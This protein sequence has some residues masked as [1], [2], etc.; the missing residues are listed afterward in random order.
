MGKKRVG[1][2]KEG[3]RGGHSGTLDC[4]R[5]RGPKE[6]WKRGTCST[7][8]NK[9]EKKCFDQGW[10]MKEEGKKTFEIFLSI[11]KTEARLALENY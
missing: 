2:G 9:R 5:R 4:Y 7:V 1:V 10:G 3:R 11:P 6:G 8:K